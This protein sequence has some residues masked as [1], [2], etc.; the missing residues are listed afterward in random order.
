[1]L[2]ENIRA[3]CAERGISIS[4]LEKGAGLGNGVISRWGESSP[5]LESVLAVA[6]F[7]DVP[8]DRLLGGNATA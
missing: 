1:M 3:L 2:I 8:V 4:A 5:R 6:S 7:L